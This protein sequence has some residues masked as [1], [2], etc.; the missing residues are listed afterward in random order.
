MNIK[1]YIIKPIS[2][3]LVF[4]TILSN[5]LVGSATEALMNESP[6]D[7][8]EVGETGWTV[9]ENSFEEIEV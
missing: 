8:I 5:L 9:D 4:G 1:K 7:E 2:T 3:M 6:I